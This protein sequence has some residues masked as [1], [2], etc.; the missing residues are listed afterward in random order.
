MPNLFLDLFPF[1]IGREKSPGNEVGQMLEGGGGWGTGITGSRGM[2]KVRKINR[3]I[4][5]RKVC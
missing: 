1:K 3:L 4:R 2:F 5:G